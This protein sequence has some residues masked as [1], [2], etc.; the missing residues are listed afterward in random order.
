M[1]NAA[2]SQEERRT[3]EPRSSEGDNE[4]PELPPTP[5]ELGLEKAP[6]R[7]RGL[8]SSSPSRLRQKRRLSEPVGSSPLKHVTRPSG[9]EQE[10]ATT[11][12]KLDWG[13]AP[14]EV[15]ERERQ[16]EELTARLRQLKDEVAELEKWA[17][18]SE[19]PDAYLE[20]SND[21][22]RKLM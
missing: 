22:T 12:L 11:G 21:E 17:K 19:N 9:P 16:K 8:L 3:S 10:Y 6:E 18:R 2:R 13:A 20:D 7:P 5:T 14:G 15:S 1:A 4:E